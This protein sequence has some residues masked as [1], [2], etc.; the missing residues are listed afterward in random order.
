MLNQGRVCTI[1]KEMEGR[2]ANA[3][4]T[5]PRTGSIKEDGRNYRDNRQQKRKLDDIAENSKPM[6]KKKLSSPDVTTV[7]AAADFP[8]Q[9][10]PL[11][12]VSVLNVWLFSWN[13]F[14]LCIVNLSRIIR[15]GAQKLFLLLMP[16]LHKI[17]DSHPSHT[18]TKT[19]FRSQ[20]NLQLVNILNGSIWVPKLLF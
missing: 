5:S 7:P 18:T 14:V 17:I 8:S 20:K 13:L 1:M 19:K 9:N 12:Q 10:I 15:R 16:V 6:K 4:R 11:L 3:R 2:D